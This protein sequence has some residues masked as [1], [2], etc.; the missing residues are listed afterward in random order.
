MNADGSDERRLTTHPA[1]DWDARWSPN[2]ARI[3][4]TSTRDGPSALFTMGLD[5]RL[6][7]KV[8]DER[9][10][11][12]AGSSWFDPDFPRSVS[13]IGRRATTWGWLKRLGRAR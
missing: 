8:T 4:F 5:G 11:D 3:L 9:F 7:Q 12:I 2:G 13:P 6:V 1:A 10:T